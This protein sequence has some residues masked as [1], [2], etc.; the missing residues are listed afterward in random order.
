MSP[1]IYSAF[2]IY[3]F[4]AIVEAINYSDIDLPTNHMKYYFNSFPSVADKCR[5][6]PLCPYK[7]RE[8]F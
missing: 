4:L 2:T 3:I 6:D 5:N 8:T 7:V 1:L